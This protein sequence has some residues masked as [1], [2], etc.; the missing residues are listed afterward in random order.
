MADAVVLASGG[1]GFD[2]FG[3]ISKYA[4]QLKGLPTTNG[5]WAMGEGVLAAEEAGAELVLMDQVQVHPTG[6][7]D[8][9]DPKNPT[10]FLAPEAL[11]GS[12]AI[13]VNSKGL[14]FVNELGLR[15]QVTQAI[16]QNCQRWNQQFLK[17]EEGE[18][19]D[20]ELPIVSYSILN[21]QAVDLFH[22]PVLTFYHS[23]FP[24]PDR[25]LLPSFLPN[26][27][28][29]LSFFLFQTERGL[30]QRFENVEGVAEALKME[31][32]VLRTTIEQYAES[33]KK[34]VDEFGKKTYP[35]VLSPDE[36][37]CILPSFLPTLLFQQFPSFLFLILLDRFFFFLLLADVAVTTPAIHYTMGGAAIDV[38]GR[39]LRKETHPGQEWIS[40]LFAAGEV[41]G[42]V[43]GANRLAGNSL[44]ECVV[45]G[46]RAGR[47]AVTMNK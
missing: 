24:S 41:S 27:D 43:H 37:L 14:R 35:V 5:P 2:R 46:R 8:P 21:D 9:K 29:L 19:L 15:D 20:T 28:D 36:P 13:M 12:G 25:Q 6:F 38:E 23:R 10:K 39:V 45:F 47:N 31:A 44:L 4:P 30:V 18:Q 34:G 40:G 42:G 16:F 11:R 22:R 1:F 33:A 32:S 26:K 3:L 17:V 7:V